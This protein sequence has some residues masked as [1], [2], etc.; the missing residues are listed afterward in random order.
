MPKK[1]I[2]A[3]KRGYKGKELSEKQVNKRVY[4]ALNNLGFMHGSKETKKGK[5]AESKYSRDHR[6]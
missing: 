6:K 1:I 4:G 3:I 5:K 2:A